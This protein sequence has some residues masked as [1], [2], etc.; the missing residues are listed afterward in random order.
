MNLK[1]KKEQILENSFFRPSWYSIFINPYFINRYSLYKSIK[2]FSKKTNG[3][4]SILDVGCGIKPYRKLFLTEKYTGIDIEGGGHSDEAKTVDKF[5]N[6]K[7]IPSE[8]NNF[9]FIICT[10]VLEHASNPYSLIR[11]ISR[12]LKKDGKV[13]ISMPF[14]YPEHETPYDFR[15][16]TQYQHIK[17][18]ENDFIDI[19]I[20]KTTGFWGTFGQIFV[21]YFFES[22]KFRASILKILLSIFILA[23]IQIISIVFD[24]IFRKSGPTM[25]Y[26][27]TATK[28]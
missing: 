16:F 1:Q 6:G 21:V 11:E 12:V 26:V 22:L 18:L 24:F 13:F 4:S 25:D 28:K 5:Y 19:K 27:I 15:R 9:D 10:Q 3:N 23:P 8:D 14:M 7:D 2:K 17:N 20:Q